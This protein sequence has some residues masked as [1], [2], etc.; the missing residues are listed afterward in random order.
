MKQH[1]YSLRKTKLGVAS[2]A[3]S[4]TLLLTTSNVA[5]VLADTSLTQEEQSKVEAFL[6]TKPSNGE[7]INLGKVTLPQP[8][9]TSYVFPGIDNYTSFFLTGEK[10]DLPTDL[11]NVEFYRYING[12]RVR[13]RLKDFDSIEAYG[14]VGENY[15][16]GVSW[17]FIKKA[18]VQNVDDN[19]E[20]VVE[21]VL[22]QS[23]VRGNVK[24]VYY[25][26]ENQFPLDIPVEATDPRFKIHN[27][28]EYYWIA[29]SGGGNGVEHYDGGTVAGNYWNIYIPIREDVPYDSIVTID[30]SLKTGE[31]VEDTAGSIGKLNF[32]FGIVYN[33]LGNDPT[34]N[35]SNF[36]QFTSDRIYNDV[37]GTYDDKLIEVANG[38]FLPETFEW[39]SVTLNSNLSHLYPTIDRQLR[40]GIDFTNFF[41]VDGTVLA[42]KEYGLT[43][44]K[45]FAGYKLVE[46]REESNG[47]RTYVYEEV[48]ESSSST[49]TPSSSNQEASPDTD[50]TTP[51]SSN[52]EASPDTDATTPSSSNQEASPDTDTTTPSLSNQEAS[53][54]TDTTTPSSSN[55]ETSPDPE[56][57]TPNK[58]TT[59][60]PST[61]VVG[62]VGLA[63]L[64]LGILAGTLTW[65][66]KEKKRSK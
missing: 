31:I 4:T 8:S 60:L 53:P 59:I 30:E 25:F 29:T 12:E 49:T 26:W 27:S 14:L 41:K 7:Q 32:N 47:D 3:L 43:E 52:Q 2:L 39:G 18:I 13:S 55:Q 35:A 10:I 64:G 66:G 16:G 34:V 28:E 21:N 48:P 33:Y 65:K 1:T 37:M 36:K 44:A 63:V 5:T 11:E 38:N 58:R 23:D 6:E 42:T 51:S 24:Y 46:T 17:Y 19:S 45:T 62:S 20:E 57:T 61:G 15:E 40:V 54:D 22:M 9:P 50:A 56:T